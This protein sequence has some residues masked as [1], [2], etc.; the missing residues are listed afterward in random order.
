MQGGTQEMHDSK[1]FYWQMSPLERRRDQLENPQIHLPLWMASQKL[2]HATRWIFSDSQS[3]D[4]RVDTKKCI[5]CPILC[6]LCQ[7]MS[8]IRL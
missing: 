3:T 8:Q 2:D 4:R 7:I 1:E 6:T 5:F